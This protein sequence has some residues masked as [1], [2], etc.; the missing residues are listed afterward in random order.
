MILK[1]KPSKVKEK[2]CDNCK[3][4]KSCGDLP[5]FCILMYYIMI[6]SVVAG[7]IYLLITMSL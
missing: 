1:I 5:Y 4:Q 7:L 2:I 3:L 6:A